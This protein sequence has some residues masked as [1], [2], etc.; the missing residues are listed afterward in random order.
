MR[1]TTCRQKNQYAHVQDAMRAAERY[2]D[3][4]CMVTEFYLCDECDRYH[5]RSKRVDGQQ[6]VSLEAIRKQRGRGKP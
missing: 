4:Y 1:G 5:L 2:T 6:V 3:K